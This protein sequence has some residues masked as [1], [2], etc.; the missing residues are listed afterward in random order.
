MKLKY[1]NNSYDMKAATKEW[2]IAEKIFRLS[3]ESNP[4]LPDKN[5]M[6]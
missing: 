3:W 5:P 6:L 2:S 4:V 1:N